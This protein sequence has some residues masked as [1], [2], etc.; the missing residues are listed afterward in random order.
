[1]TNNQFRSRRL[2]FGLTQAELAERVCDEVE[3]CTGR[4]PGIDAQ[5]ISRIECGD[6]TWPRHTTRRALVSV[7]D[8]GSEAALGL[9]PRRTIRDA[10]RDEATKRRDFLAAV[11]TMAA[12]P[13][14]AG[15]ADDFSLDEM[16]LRFAR[17]VELDNHL[18]GGDTFHLYVAELA[19]TERI[20]ADASYNA[21]TGRALAELAAQQAQQAGWAA[22]DAGFRTQAIRFFQ[23]S[24]RAANEADKPEL[25]ANALLHI[26]YAQ[27]G[28]EGVATADAAC[29]CVGTSALPQARILLESRRAWARATAGDRSGAANS[30]DTA[31]ALLERSSRDGAPS[32]CAWIDHAELDIMTGRV[33]SVLHCPERATAPLEQALAT[34]PD[35][36]SRDKSLYLTWLADAYLDAGNGEAALSTT[37][38]ALT[39]AS[40][41][42]SVRPLARVRQVALRCSSFGIPGSADI[43][44]RTTMVRAPTPLRL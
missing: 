2:T 13:A 37:E 10:E 29:E 41:T 7:L 1:M 16:N 43:V 15:K 20:L 9:Y 24:R 42:A 4:R 17:L 33:W 18:G 30:L 8:S 3:R 21:R 19:N 14:L 22:F 35:H 11:S 40:R 6:I 28:G 39:M 44:Q 5:A 36:W 34:Y 12:A 27:P 26:S 23:Y 38:K 32:W 31:R 25:A